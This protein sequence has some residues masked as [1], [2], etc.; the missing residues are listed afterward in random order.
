YVFENVGN[1]R[2]LNINKCNLSDDAEYE[3]VIGE[4]KC[5]TEVFVK[6][7]PVTITKLLDDVHTVVGE[8]VEFEVEVSEEGANVKWMKDEVELNRETAG[9][10]YR[11]KK[12]G[13]KHVLIITEATKEDIGMYY[14]FTNGGESKAELE[15]E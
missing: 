7:P 12:D 6:E 3:C 11:F 8:K 4:E 2:T 14:A 13:K 5:F 15:V 1:K 9:S 10:K